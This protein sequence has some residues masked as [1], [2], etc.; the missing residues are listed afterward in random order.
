MT[1]DERAKGTSFLNM[2]QR[3]V[4]IVAAFVLGAAAACSSGEDA[5]PRPAPPP[6]AKRV[7]TSKAGALSG[8]VTIEG[9]VPPSTAIKMGGDPVCEAAHKDGTM[10]ETFVTDNGGL[11][12][13]FVYVRDGLG[14]YYFEPPSQP[15]RLDQKGC[16]YEPHV[17]GVQVGQ[18]IEFVNSDATAHNVHAL[19]N[20]NAEFN[21]SQQIQTQKNSRFFSKPEVMV[22]I[23]CD[24][25]N[26]MSAY[27]GVLEHPYFSVTKPGG[28]FELANL[29]AGS[30]IVEAWH[31]KLGTE[32]QQVTLADND[33]KAVTFTFK[34]SATTP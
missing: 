18:N 13:V 2:N 19:P 28:E 7:D 24:M 9:S 20:A 29:P 21:F 25:H 5:A 27:A 4:S 1:F 16:R 22:R 23:K 30:Y 33:K 11:G 8:R 14:G 32:S 10:S 34:A 17:F 15:V 12:N 6:D 26:W 3:T 31:E